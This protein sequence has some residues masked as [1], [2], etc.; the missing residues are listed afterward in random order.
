MK[1]LLSALVA[2]ALGICSAGAGSAAANWNQAPGGS[3]NFD[4]TQTSSASDITSVGGVPHVAWG[5]SNGTNEELRVKQLGSSGW[6]AI[7]GALNIDVSMGAGNP[8]ITSIAGV[9]YVAWEEATSTKTQ[10]YVKQFTGGTWTAVGSS[11]NAD[12]AKDGVLPS[13]TD[14]GGVP[15][16]AYV[17][18]NTVIRVRQFT[19][20][21]WM[22]VGTPINIDQTKQAFHPDLTSIGGVPYIVWDEVNGTTR[23]IHVKQFTA[24]AWTEVGGALNADVTKNAS[25]P[26]IT[27]I[28]GVP[29]VAWDEDS[30]TTRLVHV[31]RFTGGVWT[32]VGDPLNVDASKDAE[33]PIVTSIAGILL[34]VWRE[35]G[36]GVHVARFAGGAWTP[37]GAPLS[38]D[39]A[40][41]VS[42][43]SITA[44]GDVPYVAWGEGTPSQI[45]AKRLEPDILG[46][47][48]TPTTTGAT[49]AAQVD[50]F[51]LSLPVGFEHGQTAMFGT[52]TALQS[53]PGTGM[54][55][56]TQAV[57][58]LTP[59]TTYFFR[60]F[61][62]DTFRQT[63]LG[64]TQTFTTT[65]VPPPA[66][67]S[68]I[69]AP[70]N[71][72]SALGRGPS[73]AKK[74]TGTTV[75]YRD[76]QSAR[77]TFTVLRRTRGFRAGKRCVAQHPP[78]G[79]P[80]QR[81]TRYV[82]VG[83]FSRVDSAGANSFRFTGRIKRRSLSPGT[84]RLKAVPKNSAGVTG[85]AATTA[86][87]I[88]R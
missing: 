41:G 15:Y 17:E 22:T 63:S 33:R 54:S 21:A 64:A 56:L 57:G 80:V 73:I 14:V 34:V 50:D 30:G 40:A 9:P 69:L 88:V 61:G 68:L 16:V 26:S 5:E 84:Y 48:A 81:C 77:T 12:P 85:R 25:H 28:G 66:L 47:S 86:F 46:Q 67:S 8:S 78:K 76:S 74:R 49:L 51:G 79:V 71:F 39:P 11:I 65:A 7:G 83:G 72:R 42:R 60:A 23:L 82:P 1:R 20:G 32:A 29:I 62:S 55:T 75:T 44:V 70:K 52:Q 53:S 19:G 3:L 58:G 43:P 2:A 37:I 59:T 24:G 45:R 18:S 31:K 27:G 13:I 4:A 10:I 6:T 35:A 36:S 87:R 38:V